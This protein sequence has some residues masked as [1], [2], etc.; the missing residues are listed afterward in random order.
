V[1][2]GQISIAAGFSVT[3]ISRKLGAIPNLCHVLFSELG[4]S[5]GMDAPSCNGIKLPK[6]K[7]VQSTE[8]ERSVRD[9]DYDSGALQGID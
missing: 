4:K 3:E 9:E 7:W 5:N 6:W 1:N 8:K 2:A